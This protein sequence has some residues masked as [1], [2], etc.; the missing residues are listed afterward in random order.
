MPVQPRPERL[1]VLGGTFDPPHMGHVAAA[2][3]CLEQLGLDRVLFVVANDPWQKSPVRDVTPAADRLAMVE[4]AVRSVP[5]AEASRIELD[6]GGPSYTVETVEAL[7]NSARAAGR[8]DP[9]QFLIVGA[10]VIGSLPTWHR[11]ACLAELVTLVV[12]R[13]PG[14]P[15][16]DR[17]PGWRLEVVPGPELDLSSSEVREVLAAGRSA[18]GLVPEAVE[19]YIEAHNLY[20]VHR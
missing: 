20:A 8:P 18:H 17:V 11:A 2:S 10:D 16:P 9:E 19:R 15:G 12:L 4:A 3:A 6:R 7:A 14:A 5:R 1:G 13:R